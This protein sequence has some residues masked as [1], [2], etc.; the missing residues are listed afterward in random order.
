MNAAARFQ[1]IKDHW[2][3]RAGDLDDAL[4]YNRKL[5]T[6]L[7]TA[8]TEPDSPWP[9]AVRDSI[10]TL[11]TFTFRRTIDLSIEPAPEKLTALI[12]INKELAAG[13]RTR[14]PEQAGNAA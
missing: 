12:N 14:P 3:E 9:Q 2:N 6:I 10:A 1:G 7:V 11:G 5:W 13:L 4:L 8:V